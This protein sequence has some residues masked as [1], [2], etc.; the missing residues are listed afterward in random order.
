MGRVLQ[1]RNRAF[2]MG[3][4]LA[5]MVLAQLPC[6]WALNPA[7][8][9][10][11]YAH[12]AWKIR[13]G[14]SEGVIAAITQTP[15][16]YLWLGTEFGLL[17]FD[18]VKPEPWQP[19]AGQRLPNR[20]V[21][22]LLPARDGTL[23]I[24]TGGGLASWKDG[25]LTVY[26]ELDGQSVWALL[27]DR[28]GTVW[29]GGQ[30]EP[31]A[32][33]CAVRG[34]KVECY[35]EDGK[36]GQYIEALYEDREG[37]LW[38]GGITGLW[39]WK[40]GPPVFYP[41][42]D[43][44]QALAAGDSGALTIAMPSGF[45][46]LMGGKLQAYPL[47]ATRPGFTARSIF[48]DRDGGVWIGTR[49]RGIVHVHQGRTDVFERSDGLSGDFVERIF[50]DREG[51]IWVATI[52]G[53]DRF[54]DIAVPTFS[55][56]QGLSDSTVESV[57]AARDGSVWL[58]TVDGLNRWVNGR[59][60]TYRQKGA[61]AVAGSRADVA[62]VY[63]DGLPDNAIES[64]YQ[65]AEDRIWVSTRRGLAYLEHDRFT[66]VPAVP[67][68]VRAIA[69]DRE[70]N[71]WLS[72]PGSLYHL[73]S[74]TLVERIPWNHVGR[75]DHARTLISDPVRGGIWLGFQR[76]VSYYKDG[77]PRAA[78]SVA[79]G[80][81]DGRVRDLRL[82]AQG[83]LW[84]STEAGLSRLKDGHFAT[85]TS[86]N[87]LPCDD[88]QW[89][90]EDNDHFFWLYMACGLV[91]VAR[92]ELEA[93]SAAA[94][95]DVKRQVRVTVF[96]S[97]DGVRTHSTT[98]GFSPSVAKS[99]DG[100][101][102]F[103]PWDGASVVDPRVLPFNRLS[104]PVYITRIT[105]DHNTYNAPRAGSAPVRLPALV[106]DLEIDYTA[107]SM[108]AQEKV[109][110]R[111]RLEGR[112]P[113]WKDVGTRRSAYYDSLSPGTYRF[114]VMACN[115][116]GVWA[117]AGTFPELSVPPA[118]YQAT[119][120]RVSAVAVMV[121]LL[122]ALYQMRLRQVAR[123]F[124][125]R[126]E[127]RLAERT[128]IAQELHDTLLQGFLSASMQ[129]DV[130]TDSLP[131]DS[132]VKATLTRV[133]QLMRQVVDEGRN[134]V[135]GLR[136]YGS[137]SL[138]LEHAF[139]L[140]QQEVGACAGNGQPIGFRVIVEGQR[141]PLHPLLRDEA[142]R[143]GREA[144]L[145]AF[146]HARARHVEVELNYSQSH[147]RILVRDDGCGIDPQILVSGRDGHW[148]LSG[149]RERAEQIG[150]RLQLS[151]SPMAGTEVE[152]S[153]PGASAFVGQPNGRLAW[154]LDPGPLLHR[155]RKA[156]RMRG[157]DD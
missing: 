130:A 81:G 39:R 135:R 92:T 65:D 3:T 120:F 20:Y 46:Q 5:G 53:L 138:D 88:V 36:F 112:D 128:R 126:M 123:Q 110:F 96:D 21:R 57:L 115:N 94:E 152:L 70:G 155:V 66:T 118:Y 30:A 23:W 117:E 151:S 34:G 141:R 41:T 14:F 101:I 31:V 55:A 2:A 157:E 119:W 17:R 9:V 49:D 150:G 43:G 11:Q 121:A 6:A 54:H 15:D 74:G 90:V 7:L 102:W 142:Y 89:M 86:R 64:L 76:G 69:G 40:P 61:K 33:L 12:T 44:V 84:A 134:A 108:V 37:S 147:L 19:P 156:K 124:N 105:A 139:S 149:M 106:R 78:Y 144:L 154:L 132:K 60:T 93:W 148:G 85:L 24:A 82:D 79:D 10:S 18:G 58:S 4:L 111:Y 87:G 136:S 47:A 51:S 26:P 72:H 77:Q 83:T 22:T 107:L 129:L 113:D 42:P 16:G 62:E 137:E 28:E 75:P 99:A 48:H 38:V 59:I 116:S 127:E 153:V 56:K 143:I 131:A 145:N 71:L 103:L 67:G 35:G 97:S 8:D 13:E 27:E 50:E 1:W 52:D 25:K 104:P 29:V 80:L 122:V 100:K 73:H 32:R 45:R 98:T 63:V 125:I 114:R 146:R 95:R 91:R 140:V 68:G 133:L 109:F